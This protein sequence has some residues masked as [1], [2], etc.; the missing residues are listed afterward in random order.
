MVSCTAWVRLRAASRRRCAS[1]RRGSD[2]LDPG[3]AFDGLGS[4]QLPGE[5][6]RHRDVL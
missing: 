1:R 6:A 4:A 2:E 3:F 5:I